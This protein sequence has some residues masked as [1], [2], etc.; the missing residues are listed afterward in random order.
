ML[1]KAPRGTKDL[2]GDEMN[3]WLEME[4]IIRDLCKDFGYGEIRTPVFEHT[5]LFQRGVGETTDIVQKEMYTFQDKKGRSITLKP[6]GTAG[7]VR[8]YLEQ[9]LYAGIQPTRL[10]YIT[11]AFRYEKP[12]AGRMRQFHQFGIEL[13]GSDSPTADAEVITVAYE[14]LKRVGIS[15]V[16]LHINSLGGPE[17]RKKYN[18]KLK[19]YLKDNLD[20]LCETC[21]D[22]FERNPLRILDC[23]TE[24]CKKI[25]SDAPTVLDVLGDECRAHFEKVKALL[26]EMGIPYIIDPGIVRGLDYYTK[27]VFEFISTDIGAQGTICGGGR[28]NNLVEELGGQPTPAV[29]FA[30]GLERL[31]LVIE[32]ENGKKTYPV[33]K[34]IFIGSIGDAALLKAHS[35]IYQLRQAGVTAEGD[36]F[37]K[38]VKAQMKYADKIGAKYSM[39]IGDDEINNG[40]AI[41]KNMETKEEREV[42]LDEL[43]TTMKSIL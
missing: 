26:D 10:Y 22:R 42:H 33:T 31:L 19:E 21:R 20:H 29:G 7:A 25:V 1:T 24:S 34:D 28:Y 6:E 4:K 12:Q 38:S 13:L 36:H 41:L 8:A 39:I 9:K 15:K 30:V 43:V 32:A 23:K 35:L 40:K 16:K 37:N 3:A 5:E 27:T 11:P 18:E 14:L 2:F 17:C